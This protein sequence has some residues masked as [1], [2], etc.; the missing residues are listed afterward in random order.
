MGRSEVI[1]PCEEEVDPSLGDRGERVLLVVDRHA[2]L[3]AIA[4]RKRE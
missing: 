1:V 2:V 4:D 3:A